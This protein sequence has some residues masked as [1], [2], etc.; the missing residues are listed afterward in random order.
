MKEKWR[1]NYEFYR[2][3]FD[4]SL[5]VVSCIERNIRTNLQQH[6]VLC[7]AQGSLEHYGNEATLWTVTA[8][9]KMP[10]NGHKHQGSSNAAYQMTRLQI[11]PKWLCFSFAE[12][13]W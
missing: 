12:V 1:N 11:A 10:L 4:L 5:S 8:I 13:I 2:W 7:F 6:S 9:P 3:R